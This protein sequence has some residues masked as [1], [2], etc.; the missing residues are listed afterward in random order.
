MSICKRPCRAGVPIIAS[1]AL[2]QRGIRLLVEPVDRF[3][4]AVNIT[5]AWR[6]VAINAWAVLLDHLTRMWRL[7]GRDVDDATRCRSIKTPFT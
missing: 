7:Q 4:D 6:P 2:A 3:R 5:N 1:G